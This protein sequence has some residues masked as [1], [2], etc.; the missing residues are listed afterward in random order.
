MENKLN[1]HH[2]GVACQDIEATAY[3][4]GTIGYSKGE[5]VVD[6][7]QNVQI[8]FLQHPTMPCIELLAPVDENSPVVQILQKNG[9]TPYHIC[10]RVDD[11]D[12]TIKALKRSGY[13]VVS[14]EKPACAI[15]NL[16]V[17]FLYKPS[18]GLIELAGE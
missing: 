13:L 18:M 11:L 15:E 3:E 10:Y 5:I 1:F 9:T 4:Y 8:C 12:Y 17:A 6:P 14:K 16:R 7:L 2:I